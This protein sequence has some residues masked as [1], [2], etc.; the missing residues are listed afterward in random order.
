[1]FT[2]VRLHEWKPNEHCTQAGGLKINDTHVL[3]CELDSNLIRVTLRTA[4]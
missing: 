1:M 2:N 3:F 4:F